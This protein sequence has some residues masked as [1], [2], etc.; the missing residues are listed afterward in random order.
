ME[1]NPHA[2]VGTFGAGSD[3]EDDEE[4]DRLE[5]DKDGNPIAIA[6]KKMI[7]PLPVIY[8]SEI[9]YPKFEK[10]FYEEHEDMKQ[11]SGSKVYELRKKLGIQVSGPSPPK[12]VTSFGHF[13]FDEQLMKVIRKLEYVQ[14]TAIQSQAIPVALSG[15]DLI[16]IAK[17]YNGE[18]VFTINSAGKIRQTHVNE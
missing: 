18:V 15:R 4:A 16:G 14:P 2:G 6:G 7:D 12:P 5:Y 17:T 8:H 9:E 1:A 3:A 10:N 11:L 13:G